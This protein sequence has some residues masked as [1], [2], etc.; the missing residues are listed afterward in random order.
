MVMVVGLNKVGIDVR[1]GGE[2]NK[3][4]DKRYFITLFTYTYTYINI[5]AKKF[6]Y[7][8]YCYYRSYSK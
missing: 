4:G 7:N 6:N 1:R 2:V 3:N 5:S 8:M